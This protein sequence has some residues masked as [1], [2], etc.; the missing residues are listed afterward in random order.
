MFGGALGALARALIQ[1]AVQRYTR[2]PGWVAIL[3]VNVLGSFCIGFTVSYISRDLKLVSLSNMSPAAGAFASYELNEL[4]VF[5][6]VGFCGAFTTFSTFALDTVILL[7]TSRAQA[8]I[9][10][11]GSILLAYGAVLSGWCIG[12][13]MSV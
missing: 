6:A 8:F 2:W 5:L 11:I 3:I 4:Q 13:G 12:G 1:R 9:N 7:Y 10:V